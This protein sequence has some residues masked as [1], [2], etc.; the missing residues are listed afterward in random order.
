MNRKQER[1]QAFCLVFEKIFSSESC[2]EIL[3]TASENRD[4]EP[5]EY[6]KKVF[7]GVYDNLD[8]IDGEINKRLSGWNIDRISKTALAALRL[9]F[10]EIKYIPE[11]PNSVSVNEAV[12]LCKTYGL[13]EDASYVNGVLGAYLR[14]EE[15]K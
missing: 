9:S 13:A 6:I 8:E 2:D 4:F 15:Q 7:Y 11:I 5:S 3:A 1:E 12:E 10:Y 14:G